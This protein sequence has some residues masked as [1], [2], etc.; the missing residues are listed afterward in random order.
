LL[1]GEIVSYRFLVCGLVIW[2]AMVCGDPATAA[3]AKIPVCGTNDADGNAILGTLALNDNSST[4][5]AYGTATGDHHLALL[6]DVT[7]CTLPSGTTI[8][9]KQVTILPAKAGDDLPGDPTVDV[10]V[11]NP[12]DA[13]AVAATVNLKLD[14]VAPGTRGGIVR[15]KM[16]GIIHDSFTPISVSRTDGLF[17]PVVLGLLGALAGLVW[18]IGLHVS[19]RMQVTFGNKQWAVL[20]VL[21]IGAGAVA[22]YSY[23]DNQ[24][25]W[26]AGANGF[27]TLAAGFA[28]STVG[29]LAGVTA[30]LYSPP[31]PG[32][33]Q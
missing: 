10:T 15:I 25:V 24:D 26:T 13:T 5:K 8:E 17:W 28:A 3:A 16:P 29:A 30:A 33:H 23:W 18:A 21:T 4:I 22:G 6:F 7:G 19:D 12:P 32:K 1:K 11:D 31:N 9:Q 2:L 14:D 27:A 20:I